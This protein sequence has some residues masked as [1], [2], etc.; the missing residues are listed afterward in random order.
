MKK[1][2]YLHYRKVFQSTSDDKL[3]ALALRKGIGAEAEAALEAELGRRGIQHAVEMS[4]P[5][6]SGARASMFEARIAS[7]GPA[8]FRLCSTSI[9]FF[10]I[11][12]VLQIHPLGDT[13][14]DF[15]KVITNSIEIVFLG[16]GLL[17]FM[18]HNVAGVWIS[19][20][21]WAALITTALGSS[22]TTTR[23]W[24][25]IILTLHI[26]LILLGLTAL[27]EADL[28]AIAGAVFDR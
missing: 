23:L 17:F 19:I 14:F 20:A 2:T 26:V 13:S 25:N 18:F 1:Q 10:L 4:G 7:I 11:A 27:F 5:I 9:I 22:N 6:R 15:G 12:L 24:Y 3:M 16:P 8:F 21:I 28:V